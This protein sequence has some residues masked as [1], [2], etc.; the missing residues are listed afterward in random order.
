MYKIIEV[1]EE[2]TA[3]PSESKQESSSVFYL[4]Y[5]ST[6]KTEVQCSSETSVNFYRRHSDRGLMVLLYKFISSIHQRP[7]DSASQV[8]LIHSSEDFKFISSIRL[9]P[10]DSA[11]Q[12]D[13]IH[14][15]EA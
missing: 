11:L 7:D 9:R 14:S 3:L 5:F 6:L 8:Y 4:A 1:S 2:R 10:A 15:L 13:L 12:V